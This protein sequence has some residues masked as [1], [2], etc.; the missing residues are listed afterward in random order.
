MRTP[1]TGANRTASMVR[2]RDRIPLFAVELFVGLMAVPCGILLIVNGLGMSR[3]VL[4]DSPFETF[5]VPGLLLAFVVGGSLLGA[6]IL[7]WNRKPIAPLAS[8][9]AGSVLLGWIVV[10]AAMVASGRELQAVIFA[11]AVATLGL[12]W[13]QRRLAKGLG[14]GTTADRPRHAPG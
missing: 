8:L 2:D 7:E 6:A 10:E 1:L 11:L 5:L 12:A 9:G 13:D 14:E 3:E 4:E